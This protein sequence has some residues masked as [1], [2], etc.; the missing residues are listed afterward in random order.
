MAND[1]LV[2]RITESLYGKPVRP[3]VFISYHHSNDQMYYNTL[4]LL[5]D[6]QY[7]LI[8]DV[9]LERQVNS[10]DVD[11]VRWRIRDEYIRGTSCTVVL[12]GAQTPWR[13]YVDWEIK[14]TLDMEHALVAVILPTVQRN[15]RN[16]ALVPDRM[17]DNIDSKYAVTVD[18]TPLTPQSFAVAVTDARNRASAC[19]Y[20][21][22][23]WRDVRMRNA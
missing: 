20:L 6:D 21:I 16:Q 23:N 7:E 17:Y 8:Q 3:K 12:C 14:A 22:R 15:D 9:S 1:D 5:F 2:R 10:D 13:K 11:Y 18:W 19:K 4:S